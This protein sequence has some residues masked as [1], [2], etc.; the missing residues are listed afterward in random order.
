MRK[1]LL[2]II[3]FLSLFSYSQTMNVSNN[4]SNSIN[5]SI[6]SNKDIMYI[7]WKDNR[8]GDYEYYFR[9]YN[10][11]HWS[12]IKKL[13]IFN[14]VNLSSFCIG[15]SNIIHLLWT[16]NGTSKK[17]IY[18]RILDSTLIDSAEI[19]KTDSSYIGITSCLFDELTRLLHVTFEV[20]SID[21]SSTYY[22][23]MDTNYVWSNKEVIIESKYGNNHAKILKGKDSNIVCLWFNEDSLNVEMM[24]KT[25]TSWIEGTKLINGFEGVGR[26]FV[27]INDDSLNIHFVSHP[28]QVMTC[29]CNYLLYSK[30][31]GNQWSIPE[32]VPS[33]DEHA[34]NTEH[35]YPSIALSKLN[36]PVI[37]WQQNSWDI[38]MNLT[39]KFIG[40]ALKTDAG[41]HVNTSLKFYKPEKPSISIDNDDNINYVW[42]D[43]TGGDYDIYFYRTSLLTSIENDNNFIFPDKIEL[44]QNY[45]NP[46][47]P[48]TQISFYLPLSSNIDLSIYNI[49]GQKIKTLYN[50][51]MNT[52]KKE[53]SWDGKNNHGEFV[54]SGIYIYK[55]ET[56]AATI[57]R[58]MI[59][60]K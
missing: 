23:F 34:Y 10:E 56:D 39:N 55:L 54:N 7:F 59:L 35:N 48:N 52:G 24:E 17:L 53:I 14:N 31:D 21:T 47:N 33:N 46:F 26:N 32:V 19:Y 51:F 6:I 41:W 12:D 11:G 49:I 57:S 15:D 18:G 29:P 50:G 22:L 36:Y 3:T 38:Y 20:N 1:L 58:K 4:T 2:M 43:S 28:G 60:I 40:T 37:C 44:N 30:W 8:D 25:D 45:P 13:K 42:Q 27:A 5:P 9:S 16:E